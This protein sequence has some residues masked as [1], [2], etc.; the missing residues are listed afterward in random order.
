ML[1]ED[2]FGRN[3]PEIEDRIYNTVIL[4]FPGA[5][6]AAVEPVVEQERPCWVWPKR[7]M[8]LDQIYETWEE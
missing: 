5:I 3:R 6:E 7:E 4:P 1:T 2:F 8:I